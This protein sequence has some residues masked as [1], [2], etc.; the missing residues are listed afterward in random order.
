M[1]VS[2]TTCDMTELKQVKNKQLAALDNLANM[3]SLARNKGEEK[4]TEYPECGRSLTS[5]V[6][7]IAEQGGDRKMDSYLAA[8]VTIES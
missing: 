8:K 6:R 4:R 5:Q 7:T 2:T 1:I 3:S